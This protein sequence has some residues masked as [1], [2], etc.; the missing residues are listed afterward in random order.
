MTVKLDKKIVSYKVMTPS[1][2]DNIPESEPKVTAE[3]MERAIEQMH[4]NVSR[5]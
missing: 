4:E 5:P 1:N 3:N 2:D